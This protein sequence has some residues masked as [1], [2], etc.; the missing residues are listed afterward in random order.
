MRNPGSMTLTK[1]HLT[2]SIHR[3]L[4]LPKASSAVLVGSLFEIIKKTL[5]NGDDVLIS[6]FGKFFVK[7]N[8]KRRGRNSLPRKDA[9]LG[10]KR[11]VAFKCSSVL[12]G[13]MNGS[14]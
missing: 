11:V 6:G 5:G 4:G 14:R 7:G 3:R 1:S 9:M 10:S 13:L 2:D 12:K 8:N